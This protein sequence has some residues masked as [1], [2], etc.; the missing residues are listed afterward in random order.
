MKLFQYSIIFLTLL[1]LERILLL[2]VLSCFILVFLERLAEL[3]FLL[4]NIAQIDIL[5]N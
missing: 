5:F 2:I 1:F 3:K 4:I